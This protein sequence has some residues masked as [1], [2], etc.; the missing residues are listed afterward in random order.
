MER[1]PENVASAVR[2]FA[3][4]RRRPEHPAA[5]ELVAYHEKRLSDEDHGAIREHLALC[6]ECTRLLLDLAS[7][8]DL[9]PPAESDSL[10]DHDLATLKTA[11]DSR[12]AEEE[13]AA[14]GETSAKPGEVVPFTRPVRYAVPPLY[15][16]ALAA[17]LLVTVGLGLREVGR[18]VPGGGTPEL[19]HLYPEASRSASGQTFRIPP[20]ADSY[21]LVLG[22][23]SSAS[24][25]AVRMEVRDAEG[26]L[27]VDVES[28]PR[29]GDGTFK[30]SLPRGRLPE[31]TWEIRLFGLGSEPPEPLESYTFHLVYDVP[32]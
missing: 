4:E 31:G 30:R 8:G 19:F 23:V 27:V 32:R 5:D 16:A 28:L 25:T 3:E 11:L 29:S 20:W 15:W 17:L 6:G 12:L 2:S 22:S 18:P 14:E 13:L 1:L 10:D 7:F 24:H 9:R 26:R 21:V